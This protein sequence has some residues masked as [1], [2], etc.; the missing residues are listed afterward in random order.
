MKP[1]VLLVTAALVAFGLSLGSGFHFD[2]YS[3]LEERTWHLG[4]Q[5]KNV[6]DLQT[7]GGNVGGFRTFRKS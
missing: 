5:A 2:D 7:P 1:R 4:E 3:I 6:K